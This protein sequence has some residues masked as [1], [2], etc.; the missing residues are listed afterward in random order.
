MVLKALRRNCELTQKQ[1]ASVLNIDR[2]TYAYYERGTTEPDLKSI[3]KIAKM[4]NVDV[5]SLLPDGEGKPLLQVS[6]ITKEEGAVIKNVKRPRLTTD[7]KE[8]KIYALSEDEQDLVI[9]YR[10][11]NAGNQ[12]KVSDYIDELVQKNNIR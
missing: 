12:L 6:D 1:I 8:P 11:L 5:E 4:M 2:S 3:L 10:I 7:M 9:R